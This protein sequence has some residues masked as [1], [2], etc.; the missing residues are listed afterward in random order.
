MGQ[1]ASERVRFGAYEVDLRS[2]QV[3]KHGR[4]VRLQDQP[5]QVL[6]ALLERPGEIITREEL[7]ERIWPSD[8][9]VDFDHSLNKAV[10]KVRQ[11]LGDSADN[12]RFVESL[13]RRGYRFI[14]PVEAAQPPAVE[15]PAS[16][17]RRWWIWALA[18]GAAVLGILLVVLLRQPA[19]PRI[20][21][22]T[23]LTNDGRQKN[24]HIHSD[25]TWIYFTEFD[26]DRTHLFQVPVSGGEPREMPN[27]FTRAGGRFFIQD[28]AP[29]RRDLLVVDP[30]E[31]LWVLP[32][33]GGPARRL[34]NLR[35]GMAVWSPDG[36]SILFAQ[37]R[38]LYVGDAD[39]ALTQK[40]LEMPNYVEEPRWS[41]D[42]KRIRF[43]CP[44]SGP[45]Y[46]VAIWEVDASGAN[47]HPLFP[48]WSHSSRRGHWSPDGRYFLFQ[49]PTDWNLWAV[50]E[51]RGLR[52]RQ[53][54]PVQLTSGPIRFGPPFP[55]P[56]GK[57]LYSVGQ[58][59]RGELM[60]YDGASRRFV[61]FLG[62]ISADQ[63]DCS[64]DGQ[65][66]AYVAYPEGTL[67][68]SRMDSS[69]R[70]QLSPPSISSVY[71]PRWSPDGKRIVFMGRKAAEP[72][73]IYLVSSEGGAAEQ[74][75]P[76]GGTEADPNWSPDGTKIIYAPF[77]WETTPENSRIYVLDL[78]TRQVSALPGSEG[79]FSPRWSPDN[80][81]IAALMRDTL[82]LA[83]FD[84]VDRKW[85]TDYE[86]RVAF[87]CWSRDGGRLY[88]LDEGRAMISRIAV[89]S[90][91][92]ETVASY[93]GMPITGTPHSPF[94][95]R[96]VWFGLGPDDSPLLI[97]ETGNIEIYA[98]DWEA[99]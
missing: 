31:A 58:F 65:W 62:G 83:L 45:T 61:P 9:F 6:A 2:R 63:V 44:V 74:L 95:I 87:P 80:R 88:Y 24:Q 66:V 43:T 41:P 32:V 99:P 39:G 53:G 1:A 20:L 52:L 72:W 49:S 92:V 30:A 54:R 16:Q 38:A 48:G 93:A 60:R 79:L 73:K 13:A 23:Q 28:I 59:R 21:R 94:S 34:G 82:K 37:G 3:R 40:L 71:L 50:E 68:R 5:F 26:G 84:T 7:R 75:I 56:D 97:R 51:K 46:Q 55:I 4:Q 14:A 91:R 11:A 17:P 12:P 90:G 25:G 15:Q 8:T 10:N 47:P 96:G 19:Q 78:K 22:Y 76:G 89:A 35:G 77:P 67:W 81:F 64:R 18:A 57:Q 27:Q 98:L 42:G 85:R 70:L 29:N 36:R 33:S 86:V 69:E